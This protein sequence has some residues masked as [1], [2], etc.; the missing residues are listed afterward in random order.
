MPPSMQLFAAGFVLYQW[1]LIGA[2]VCLARSNQLMVK[3]Q[4]KHP[5]KPH[6]FLLVIKEVML[7]PRLILSKK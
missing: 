2:G 5:S 1:F 3:Y 6:Q 7:W 4:G